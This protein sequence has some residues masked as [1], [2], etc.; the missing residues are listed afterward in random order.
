MHRRAQFSA[1]DMLSTVIVWIIAL[2]F[3]A[4]VLWLF[5]AA[6]KARKVLLTM[7]PSW[8]FHPTLGPLRYMV[9]KD[10][11]A[12]WH[13][14]ANSV[15]ISSV[16][17]VLAIFVS[18]LAAYAISRFKVP[19]T[20]FFMF[21]I[22]SI[23]MVPGAAVVVPL[24]M[25]YRKLGWTDS[26]GGMIGF[27]AMFSIPF[28]L[29]ILK[30]FLDG[31]SARYD[32]AALLDGASRSEIMFRLILP[33]VRPGLV[34]A[35]IF[36]TIF[37]WNEFLFDFILGGQSTATMPVALAQGLYTSQGTDWEY[38]AALSLVYTLPLIVAVYL[39]QK[40][41]LIG[42]TFGTVRGEI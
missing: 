7:P 37:V 18:Y 29:W 36:N 12:F 19:A 11:G 40:Y 16:A 33:Q 35:A 38:I 3:F 32:E 20:D 27:Y 15:V 30:G 23:R 21:L 31:V 28:S 24:F 13:Y 8:L 41:L 4:P 26:Y 5:L 2:V 10:G 17:V 14:F 9:T 42:M 22:L 25:M 39:G 34:A 1:E 6:F